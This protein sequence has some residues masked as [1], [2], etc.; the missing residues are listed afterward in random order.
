MQ[1]GD[2]AGR[3]RRGCS[4]SSPHWVQQAG[5]AELQVRH[6]LCRCVL[7]VDAGSTVSARDRAATLQ[8]TAP[9]LERSTRVQSG[10]VHSSPMSPL[11]CSST[12]RQPESPRGSSVA[13]AHSAVRPAQDVTSNTTPALARAT[14]L[15]STM[16]VSTLTW[17]ASFPLTL[18]C[19]TMQPLLVACSDTQLRHGQG[20]SGSSGRPHPAGG[21]PQQSCV[22]SSDAA[23]RQHEQAR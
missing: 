18:R 19:G 1:R 21:R 5:S 6:Q 16:L 8:S 12:R 23:A 20:R 9:A 3:P 4:C 2:S 14:S 13:Y 15:S 10:N 11:V 22:P 17:T 7:V